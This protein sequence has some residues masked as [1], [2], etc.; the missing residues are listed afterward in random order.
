MRTIKKKSQYGNY[1]HSPKYNGKPY[2]VNFPIRSETDIE[3]AKILKSIAA[4]HQKTIKSLI[5]EQIE[6]MI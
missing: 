5:M 4:I 1:D 2:R 6:S 3:A